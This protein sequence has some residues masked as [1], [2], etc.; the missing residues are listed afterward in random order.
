MHQRTP[1]LHQGQIS[2]RYPWV[3]SVCSYVHLHLNSTTQTPPKSNTLS[4]RRL[5]TRHDVQR[6]LPMQYR[7][8]C[9][10]PCYGLNHVE[11]VRASLV[12]QSHKM[13]YQ[14]PKRPTNVWL[15][16]VKPMKLQV[17]R[18]RRSTLAA[19]DT[20]RRYRTY[21]KA[22]PPPSVGVGI[23][24]SRQHGVPL[25]TFLSAGQ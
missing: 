25:Y 21:K 12:R 2:F 11:D 13:P 10:V 18:G 14:R 6:Y 7:R 20:E 3:H 9:R 8:R 22:T 24:P 17:N 1:Q 19:S 23:P 15:I 5:E 16:L 4:A